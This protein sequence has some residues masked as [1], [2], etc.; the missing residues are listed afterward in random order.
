MN[1]TLAL[2]FWFAC[3][4]HDD[5][6]PSR[7]E[8]TIPQKLTSTLSTKNNNVGILKQF[9]D[10]VHDFDYASKFDCLDIIMSHSSYTM[11]TIVIITGKRFRT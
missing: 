1:V 3:F 11:S 6:D 10:Q 5:N 9:L 4:L 7:H 8:Y 2:H